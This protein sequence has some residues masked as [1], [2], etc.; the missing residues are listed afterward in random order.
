[1]RLLAI[2]RIRAIIA[3]GIV[4]F[5]ILMRRGMRLGMRLGSGMVMR[6]MAMMGTTRLAPGCLAAVRLGCEGLVVVTPRRARFHRLDFTMMLGPAM[7]G[8][9]RRDRVAVTLVADTLVGWDCGRAM[10]RFA[11]MMMG[12]SSRRHRR[13]VRGMVPRHRR[14]HHRHGQNRR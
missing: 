11:V 9:G 7:A 6:G 8:H 10:M 4:E 1:M 14:S 13:L 3:E 12:G 2:P 5:A